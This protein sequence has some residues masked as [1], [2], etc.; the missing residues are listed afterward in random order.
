MKYDGSY[1][2]VFLRKGGKPW[3][4]VHDA[5]EGE[6][7][8]RAWSVPSSARTAK[9]QARKPAPSVMVRALRN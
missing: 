1:N 8:A 3:P 7:K 4:G 6:E 9:V 5:M 2:Y